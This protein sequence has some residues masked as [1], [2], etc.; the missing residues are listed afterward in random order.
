MNVRRR[1]LRLSLFVPL[2]L[3]LGLVCD[4]AAGAP[5]T[6]SG[7]S[8]KRSSTERAASKAK[9]FAPEK[10]LRAF[11]GSREDLRD[12][13]LDDAERHLTDSQLAPSLWR[14]IEP[15]LKATLVSDSLLRAARLYGR[16]DDPDAS[17]RLVMLLSAADPRLV[18]TAIDILAER[19]PE[20]ALK[21]LTGLKEHPWFQSSYGFR[22]AV[23]TAVARYDQPASVGFLVDIV[24]AFDGQLKYEAARELARLTGENFGG[25]SDDWRRWWAAHQEGFRVA[26]SGPP[27]GSKPPAG[28]IPWDYDVPQFFG[29]LVYAKRVVFVIDKSKSMLS[30]VDGVTRLDDA[31]RELERAIRKLPDDAWFEIIAYN[32]FE[33]PYAGKLVPATPPQKSGAVQFLYSLVAERKTD[34]YDTLSDALA[35]DPNLEAILFLSDG[36]PNVGTIVDCPTIVQ[37]ITQQNASQRTSINTI[38]IDARGEAE[39]FLKKL[40][41]DNFGEYRSIR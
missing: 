34:I 29:T 36:E 30:S 9:P 4:L 21:R 2:V 27:A 13:A 12:K 10:L 23:V 18:Q 19:R 38:G 25:K 35:V 26:D 3:G 33:Q 16:L 39:D 6:S 28:P 20:A 15:A 7:E 31:E 11:K 41:A 1:I 32:E 14:V 24:A 40:A 17:T 5:P 22:R 37:R 8:S